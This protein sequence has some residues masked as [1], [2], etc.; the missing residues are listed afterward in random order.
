MTMEIGKTILAQLGGTGRLSAMIGA[1]SF[2]A[3]DFGTN[4]FGASF[5]FKARSKN[6]WKAV[7]I[8]HNGLDLYDVS[9]LKMNNKTFEIVSKTVDNVYCDQLKEIIENETG[10]CLSL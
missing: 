9:F 2:A 6:A 10:L 5:K 4:K 3:G 8:I 7:K 1:H